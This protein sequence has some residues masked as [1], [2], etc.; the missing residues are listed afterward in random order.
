MQSFL[1]ALFERSVAMS[2]LILL[3]LAITPFLEKRYAAKW[4]YYAW[5]V[6]VLGLVIP[7][8]PPLDAAFIQVD[9]PVPPAGIQ[10]M[11]PGNLE[12]GAMGADTDQQGLPTMP[13]HLLASC[14]W[15]AGAAAVI[16]YHT[17]RHL[18][19]LRMVNRWSEEITNQHMLA[20]LQSLKDEMGINKQVKLQVCSCIT[21]P[22]LIGFFRPVVLLPSTI[23][24]SDGLPFILRHELVH[25]Q[26]NDLWYKGLVLLATAVHWFNPVV[27]LMAKAIAVQCEISCDERVLQGASFQQR[28]QYGEIIIRVVRNGAMHRTALTTNFYGGKKG[29]QTR[30]RSIMDTTKKKAGIMIFGVVLIATIGTG[31]TFANHSPKEAANEQT[32]TAA[33]TGELKMDNYS[34][35]HYSEFLTKVE[36]DPVKY[37]YNGRWVRSLYD[38]N[39]QNGKSV[40]YFN[41]VE[42]KDVLGKTAIHLRT[43]RNKETNE[44]EK[45]VEMSESEVFQLLGNDHVIKMAMTHANVSLSEEAEKKEPVTSQD[46]VAND[47]QEKKAENRIRSTES[48]QVINVDVK[49]LDSGEFVCLGKYALQAGDI[50]AYNLTAEGNGNLNVEFRKTADPRDNKGY[51]GHTGF[52]GNSVI[53]IHSPVEV[54]NALAGTYYLWVGNYQ[55]ES[56]DNIKGTVEIAAE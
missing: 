3:Y 23:M 44:I 7:F 1:T 42:D 56:L 6:I 50:I 9:L 46:H 15:I 38:E 39:N 31:M 41:A 24:T 35:D 47:V 33:V 52:A 29:M 12:T 43:I 55:G 14:L 20:M 25:L 28:K 19:F 16:A 10:L 45:L 13:W 22:M 18:R 40:L 5:L 8:R 26:R 2:V 32:L 37:Y 34:M 54:D 11:M 53:T 30:I 36:N 21:S 51:L 49:S 27:Y 48:K 4:R 17:L